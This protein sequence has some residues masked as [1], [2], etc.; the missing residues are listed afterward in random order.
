M[1]G[2]TPPGSNGGKT[3]VH[4]PK[5][6]KSNSSLGR[7]RLQV[8]D[9]AGNKKTCVRS[10][11][12]DIQKNGK[13]R[14]TTL[15]STIITDSVNGRREESGRRVEDANNE[16][17]QSMG[18][19]KAILNNVIFCHQE[20]SNWPLD[21]ASKLKL[22]FDAIF[23]TTEYNKA[24]D[25]IIKH[26]KTYQEKLKICVQDKKHKEEINRDADRKM[27][28]HD[29]LKTKHEVMKAKF[30]GLEAELVPVNE[31]IERLYMK[32]K[33]YSKLNAQKIIFE[34]T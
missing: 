5:V 25:R 30:D 21:E 14:F 13:S 10:I 19:S 31:E 22:K 29:R 3:F 2:E 1:T 11:K 15:D 9:I 28:E 17:A 7:V 4:D 32:E 6:F 8:S 26:R 34:S 24:I 18:V 20:D 23:G 16:M 27:L 33:K 12:S